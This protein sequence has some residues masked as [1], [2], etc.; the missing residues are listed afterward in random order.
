MLVQPVRHL[1]VYGKIKV[2]YL[3]WGRK[4]VTL[5]LQ[6]RVKK[7]SWLKGLVGISWAALGLSLGR[8][9]PTSGSAE[10]KKDLTLS[11]AKSLSCD[12]HYLQWEMKQV[13]IS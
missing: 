3:K 2:F 5:E 10:K 9:L 11:C 13:C 4:K 12:T 7:L 6:V 8:A 1:H